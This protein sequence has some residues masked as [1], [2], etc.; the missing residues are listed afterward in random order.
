MPAPSGAPSSV[1]STGR[2]PERWRLKAEQLADLPEPVA[3]LPRA[4]RKGS[5]L[6]SVGASKAGPAAPIP[7]PVERAAP[8]IPVT[9]PEIPAGLP[10]RVEP[11]AKRPVDASSVEAAAATKQELAPIRASRQSPEVTPL[12]VRPLVDAKPLAAVPP[13]VVADVPRAIEPPPVVTAAPAASGGNVPGVT[14]AESPPGPIAASTAPAATAPAIA[15]AT[16]TQPEPKVSQGPSVSDR[17]AVA[18]A[19]AEASVASATAGATKD[20]KRP[21]ADSPKPTVSS[22]DELIGGS[23]DDREAAPPLET[24]EGGG[25]DENKPPAEIVPPPSLQ[26]GWVI[27][28]LLGLTVL[29]IVYILYRA[30]TGH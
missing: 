1:R 15:P 18:S 10:V 5:T 24:E 26:L 22:P 30:S 7:S 2:A 25:T 6:R 28:L 29:L 19:S 8:R 4:G 23:S 20:E 13:V 9:R 27:A 3:D 16:V 11:P 12:A 17:A 21:V 14:P